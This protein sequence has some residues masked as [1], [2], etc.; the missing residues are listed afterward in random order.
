MSNFNLMPSVS[1]TRSKF[2]RKPVLK[3]SF[4]LG[5][6]IPLG[7]PREVLPGDTWKV[8]VASLI[9]M[10]TPIAPIMDSVKMSVFAFFVPSR[11]VLEDWKYFMG[12]NTDAGYEANEIE[13]PQVKINGEGYACDVGSIGDYFGLP[14]LPEQKEVNGKKI[15]VNYDN[16][17]NVSVLPIRCY[18]Q[19]YNRWFRDQNLISKIPE[20]KG[21]NADT[22]DN[23]SAAPLKA[24]KFSD[25]F[26]RALPYAQKGEAITLPLGG[27]APITAIDKAVMPVVG[28]GYT[29][30]LTD[31]SALFGLAFEG[32]GVSDSFGLRARVND[33]GKEVGISTAGG[34][35]GT[36]QQTR[37]VP[38]SEQ[39]GD[40]VYK[41]GLQVDLENTTGIY[42]DLGEATA[43]TINQLRYAFACQRYLEKSA[44]YG[45]RYAEMLKAFF[46]VISPDASI[47]DP[48]Y[49]GGKDIDINVDQVLS[50]AGYEASSSSKVGAPGANSV[51][52]YNG[53]LFTFSATEHGYIIL[54][55]CARH[56]QTYGQGVNRMWLRK[57]RFDFY[58]PTFANLG[59]QPIIN[60]EIYAQGNSED[61]D[62]FGYQEAWSEYRMEPNLCTGLLNP[63]KQNSLGF[64]DLANNFA[65]LPTLGQE[66]IEQDRNAIA[67][68]LTTGENGP[69]F[70]GDF[71]FFETVVRPMPLYSIPGLIDH[72]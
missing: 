7:R 32:T 44:L 50:T 6:L 67:R 25:Y 16:D 21:T 31:G 52:G 66:F 39:L 49:L 1:I 37:G 17:V 30:G 41:S 5:D 55:G 10:S 38:T 56:S 29:L 69:D 51:T 34:S 8:S 72:H 11:L 13:I 53:D 62:V 43:A 12:E 18:F 9:R 65:S 26:T 28:N 63:A 15:K 4:K 24:A 60:E 46:G 68:C 59:S 20:H 40:N 70:I 27:F 36:T 23:Y 22:Y 58:V 71:A 19:I 3:T 48:Q 2:T 47:Q 57:R 61:T 35:L 54:L 33:F 45:S 14:Y 64:W 42:A